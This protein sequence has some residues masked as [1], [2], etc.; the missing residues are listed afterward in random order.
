MKNHFK[1]E[2]LALNASIE[3]QEPEKPV[4]DLP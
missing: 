2:L 1:D 4:R 3:Q